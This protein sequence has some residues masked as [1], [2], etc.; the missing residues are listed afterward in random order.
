[1]ALCCC[2]GQTL[3]LLYHDTVFLRTD[4]AMYWINLYPIDS[5]VHFA[6]TYPLDSVIFPLNDWAQECKL[7]LITA[8]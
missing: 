5:A 6:I 7:V 4:N 2:L 1:M 3:N 8:N